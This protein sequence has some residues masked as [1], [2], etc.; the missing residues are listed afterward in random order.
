MAKSKVPLVLKTSFSSDT[1]EQAAGEQITIDLSAYV[2]ALSGKV[3]RVNNVWFSIDGGD[4][5]AVAPTDYEADAPCGTI[6]LTTGT[7][8]G[9]LGPQD[10]R[11]IMQAQYYYQAVDIN[12]AST[13]PSWFSVLPVPDM[14]F[15]VAADV[16]TFMQICSVDVLD[17]TT[18]WAV[19]IE[20][21]RVKLTPADINF[22][23][24]NQTLSG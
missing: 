21:E 6:Q 13:A 15:Y 23:L 2:D 22:L 14:G 5:Q 17:S 19:V 24:V 18:R 1:T 3:L 16:L 10:D 7:Q 11:V 9:L 4:A 20:A 8:T 12:G